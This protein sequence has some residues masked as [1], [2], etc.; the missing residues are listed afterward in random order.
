[1]ERRADLR[2]R[3]TTSPPSIRHAP[4][5]I[6][7]FT[8]LTSVRCFSANW[9]HDM[10]TIRAQFVF[11]AIVTLVLVC[12]M[13]AQNPPSAQTPQTPPA[14]PPD[15]QEGKDIGGFHV[16]QSIEFGGRIND[17]T[18]SQAMY[19]TLVDQQSGPRILEQSLTM[20]SLNHHDV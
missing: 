11:F 19:D 7:R 10:R 6:P 16:T 12:S 20:Q 13:A 1:M 18:G 3:I 2:D 4:C 9:R 5:A 17:V 14:A 15:A 8:G